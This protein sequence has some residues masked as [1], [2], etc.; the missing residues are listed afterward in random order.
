MKCAF[1]ANREDPKTLLIH[2]DEETVFNLRKWGNAFPNFR[3][4][5][6]ADDS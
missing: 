1:L 2:L 6:A 3:V 4:H 5:Y